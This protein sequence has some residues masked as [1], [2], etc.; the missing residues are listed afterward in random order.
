MSE[1]K[2]IVSSPLDKMFDLN[3][4]PYSKKFGTYNGVL[5]DQAYVFMSPFLKQNK[6]LFLSLINWIND[7]KMEKEFWAWK[8]SLWMYSK[9]PMI[10]EC[11]NEIRKMGTISINDN[12][13]FKNI[14]FSPELAELVCFHHKLDPNI[15]KFD[16]KDENHGLYKIEDGKCRSVEAYKQAKQI[17]PL[18]LRFLY[19]LWDRYVGNDLNMN[20]TD[21][22]KEWLI[23]EIFFNPMDHVRNDV[24]VINFDTSMDQYLYHKSNHLG[25]AQ[26]VSKKI[27]LLNMKFK[28]QI[29]W[30][31]DG[32]VEEFSKSDKIEIGL[33]ST[34]DIKEWEAKILKDYVNSMAN[35]TERGIL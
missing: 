32:F 34:K 10:V 27:Q 30:C 14:V 24:K 29:R 18:Y 23:Y 11:P 3:F 8:D 17:H 7:K 13:E 33:T 22:E 6:T 1:L 25:K 2:K 19:D 15:L 20:L 9:T 4:Y 5:K 35:G 31:F 16:I 21:Y 28:Q 26:L 12:N